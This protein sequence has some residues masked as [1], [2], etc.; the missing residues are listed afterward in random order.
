[1]PPARSHSRFYA[2]ALA[3]AYV[4]LAMFYIWLSSAWA[5]GAVATVHEL[6]SV[7]TLKG[8]LFVAATGVLAFTGALIA[9][10][11]LE[12]MASQL[13]E[14][15][16]VL[17]ANES[18]VTAGLMAA[19]VAHDANNVLTVAMA[20]LDELARGS[21]GA[22]AVPRIEKLMARLVTLNRR[23]V[24]TV[25]QGGKEPAQRIELPEVA[26]EIAAAL[27]TRAA[28]RRCRVRVLADAPC[29]VH[30]PR[31]VLQ[32]IVG[33]LLLNAIDA[34]PSGGEVEIRMLSKDGEHWLEVHDNGPG[35]PTERRADLFHA[36][37]TTKL[38]GSGL[39]LFSV[40]VCAHGIGGEVEVGDSPL[41]GALFRVRLPAY[42]APQ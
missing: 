39:G 1:M 13:A 7:E 12:R 25:Q 3:L 33:N 14:Q 38:H 27:R 28:D 15:E 20:E 26:N 21:D 16:Q 8:M 9:M 19:S 31:L 34:A 30:A 4:A 36:L 41:G 23:L 18:R 2:A 42:F 37:R 40:R 10:R 11:R 5:A 35:V 32:R 29:P 6:W 22:G 17:V 24:D